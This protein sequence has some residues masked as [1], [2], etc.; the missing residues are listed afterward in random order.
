MVTKIKINGEDVRVYGSQGQ[1]RSA[2]LSLKLAELEFIKNRIS[3][4]AKKR[5]ADYGYTLETMPHGFLCN[6]ANVGADR[7]VCPLNA[8][9]AGDR[10]RNAKPG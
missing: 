4:Q 7:R 9:D 2:A 8:K 6:N 3:S 10:K 1:Q 5:L